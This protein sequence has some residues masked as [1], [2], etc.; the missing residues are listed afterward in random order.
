MVTTITLLSTIY[1]WNINLTGTLSIQISNE[2]CTAVYGSMDRDINLSKCHTFRPSFLLADPFWDSWDYILMIFLAFA[3]VATFS[4]YCFQSFSSDP[5]NSSIE[6]SRMKTEHVKSVKQMAF[7][8]IRFSQQNHK[9]WGCTSNHQPPPLNTCEALI[10]L[11]SI[12]YEKHEA[13]AI[14]FYSSL[15]FL[16]HLYNSAAVGEYRTSDVWQDD[17]SW[18]QIDMDYLGN[19]DKQTSEIWHDRTIT[20]SR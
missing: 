20:F 15:K 17:V 18:K 10:K 12:S 8:I 11:N 19:T 16:H 3:P 13:H 1:R 9:G 7:Q 5:R 2:S 14:K 6:A 4:F